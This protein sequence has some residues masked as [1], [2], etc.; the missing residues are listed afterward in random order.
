MKLATS[1]I[2]IIRPEIVENFQGDTEMTTN[3]DKRQKVYCG[4]VARYSGSEARWFA[5]MGW[6][7]MLIAIL[8]MLQSD[9][10][11]FG[12]TYDLGNALGLGSLVLSESTLMIPVYFVISM[13]FFAGGIEWY[14]LCRHCPCYE[15]SGKEYGKEGRFYCLANWGS[16]KLFKY[17][18]SPVSTAGRLVFIA[19]VAFSYLFPIVY[20]WNRLDW[21]I[22]QLL[23]VGSFVMTLRQWCCSACP[24]FGC[25]FNSV[26]EENRERFMNEL[27]SGAI[28]EEDV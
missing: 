19:W 25:A 28:Y 7:P 11:Y 10:I 15:Y 14:V 20:F 24:N 22:V 5:V 16:P 27:K 6:I 9:I 4:I 3:D 2:Q 26:P 8:G 21:V 17:D 12:F 18:P 23:V 13:I 1:Y